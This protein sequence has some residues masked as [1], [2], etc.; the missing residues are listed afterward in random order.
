MPFV[1]ILKCS[2]GSY[3][4]GLTRRSLEA[5]INEHNAGAIPGDT[6]S[7]LPVTLA[8]HQ[9]FSNLIDAIAM[10]RRIKGWS[11]EKKKALIKGD[12]DALRNLSKRGP[13][14]PS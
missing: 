3:Y 7:R 14:T 6:K 2:D 9:E 10:E 11:R 8:F 5:G 13:A 12:Y 1:Y 4:T